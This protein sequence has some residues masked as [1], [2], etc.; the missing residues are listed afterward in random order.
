MEPRS[1][2]RG[3]IITVAD[4]AYITIR[5]QW[6][7]ARLSVETSNGAAKRG[8]GQR[9]SMEPRSIERGNLSRLRRFARSGIAS[10]EPRSIERGNICEGT[11]L[12]PL[13]ILLQWSHARLSVETMRVR[14]QPQAR[15][16]ASM[17]PRSI[18]RGN[19]RIG[20][21]NPDRNPRFN[22]ATLD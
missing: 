4:R 16:R 7:H 10:M 21:R 5:L 3:N 8:N 20:S 11:K 18:E 22:G 6:S 9:A 2:E 12:N 19:R 1:I 17:E 15:K 13:L 14:L